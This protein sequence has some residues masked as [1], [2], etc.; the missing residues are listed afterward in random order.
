MIIV[1]DGLSSFA[2]AQAEPLL[3]ALLP[4]V[5]QSGWRLAPLV[6]V[7]RGRVALQDEIGAILG[8]R[9]SLM[10]IGERP[11]LSAADSLG[12]YFTHAP[13]PGLT[14]ASRNC[15]SNIRPAG[16]P[17]AEAA[18]KLFYLLSQALRRGLSGVALKD[19]APGYDSLP[20]PAEP[21][22]LPRPSC[23]RRSTI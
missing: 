4:L 10:L 1:T 2:A 18:H 13:H 12:A 23:V 21:S 20:S 6:V 15:V 16:L 14:D 17:P 22:A 3:S 8:A 11:G 19:D 5:R 9:L 7:T